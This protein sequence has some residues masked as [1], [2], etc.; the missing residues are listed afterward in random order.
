[1]GADAR[2]STTRGDDRSVRSVKIT[3]VEFAPSGGLFQFAMQMGEAIA[4]LGHEVELVTGPDPEFQPRVSGMSLVP[5]LPTWHPGD[6]SVQP[7]IVRRL[8]R[9]VRGARYVEAW[10]RVI[11]YLERRPTDVVQWADWRFTIDGWL[12]A[13][14]AGRPGAPLMV[15]VAHTPR[16]LA[17]G[18]RGDTL[19]K[20]GPLLFSA[21]AAAYRRMDAVFVLG[22]QSRLE[23][24][25][26]WADIR[27]VEV[28]PH[29]DEA[30]FRPEGL[31]PPEACPPRVLFFG[32]W[33]RHKGLD[34]LL[35]AFALVRRSVPTADLVLAGAVGKDVDFDGLAR[36]AVAVGGVELR[37]RYI[38]AAEVRDLMGSSRV[39]VAP[40]AVAN[41]SG[42]VHIAQTFGRPVVA[43]AVGDL[44]E[45]VRH[46]ETGFLV[47]PGD[48]VAL[49]ANLEQL[50]LE[51]AEAA[52]LGRNAKRRVRESSSW[53]DVAER[54]VTVYADLISVRTARG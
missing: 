13:W 9:V 40:Y 52:R 2:E 22:E 36:R 12:V 48:P 31:P 26:T 25:R 21:L 30:I 1:M 53:R 45:V 15:D 24:I 11:A 28:I 19:Y 43:T 27:R 18:P 17:E 51:P 42:V 49:A 37:P 54:V 3:M 23:L 41:Q 6:G 8:R 50:L 7:A 4:E 35:D 39:V 16:P 44:V 5:I 29:G 32:T 14:L 46:G 34:L 38:P 20:T 10:R 33:S 47:P